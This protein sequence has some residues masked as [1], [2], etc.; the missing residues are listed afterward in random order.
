M[1]RAFV[2]GKMIGVPEDFYDFQI[3]KYLKNEPI[4]E[5][6][7]IGKIMLDYQ[8]SV[9]DWWYAMRIEY[10]IQQNKIHVIKDSKSKY[11]RMICLNNHNE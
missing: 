1:L 6:H 4:M 11:E 10:Y 3:W 9:A 8:N 5:A 7:L 2:N